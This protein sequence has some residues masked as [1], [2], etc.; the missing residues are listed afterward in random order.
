MNGRCLALGIV[1][2]KF[3]IRAVS[4]E[5]GTLPFHIII[6]PFGL[7]LSVVHEKRQVSG[8]GNHAF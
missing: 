6:T 7:S 3:L 1:L 2:V 5:L 8:C 4:T